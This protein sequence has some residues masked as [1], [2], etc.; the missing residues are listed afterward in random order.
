M[1]RPKMEEAERKFLVSI[2]GSAEMK[3][4][5]ELSCDNIY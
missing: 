2:G 1:E 4:K 3:S 5:A